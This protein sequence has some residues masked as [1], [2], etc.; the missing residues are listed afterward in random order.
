MQEGPAGSRVRAA[1]RCYVIASRGVP[2]SIAADAAE[3]AVVYA[4]SERREASNLED[5]VANVMHDGRRT[6]SRAARSREAIEQELARL[7]GAGIDTAGARSVLG[8]D[9]PEQRVLARELL[10]LLEQRATLIGSPAPRVLAGM[11]VGETEAETATAVAVSRATVT[12][13]RRALRQSA[14]DAG[15]FPAAA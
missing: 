1:L 4:L 5:L 10:T 6:V 9:S 14:K 7:S 15:Y 8:S 2:G 3:Q 13:T 11:L 12:R